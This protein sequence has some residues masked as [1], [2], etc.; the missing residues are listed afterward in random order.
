MLPLFLCLMFPSYS[1]IG[2]KISSE[3]IGA[4]IERQAVGV[5]PAISLRVILA[6]VLPVGLAHGVPQYLEARMCLG[7]Y[8]AEGSQFC[9]GH[10]MTGTHVV[11]FQQ[12]RHGVSPVVFHYG[13]HV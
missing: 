7:D 11:N 12:G 2:N 3:V 10:R 1:Q 9:S 4:P 13:F 6:K 5:E 8:L